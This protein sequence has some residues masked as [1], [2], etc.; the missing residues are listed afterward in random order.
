MT[1]PMYYELS[2]KNTRVPETFDFKYSANT[3]AIYDMFF[4]YC[5]GSPEEFAD[6]K[7]PQTIETFMTGKAPMVFYIDAIRETYINRRKLTTPEQLKGI[8]TDDDI[9]IIPVYLGHEKENVQNVPLGVAWTHAVNKNA[10]EEQKKYAKEFIDWL[11]F[12][13]SGRRFMREMDYV[14]PYTCISEK[15]IPDKPMKKYIYKQLNDKT[16]DKIYFTHALMPSGP[17]RDK[18]AGDLL[19][20][21]KGEL[22]WEQVSDNLVNSWSEGFKRNTANMKRIFTDVLNQ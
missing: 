16:K 19:A 12:S 9:G 13:E 17:Y 20:Y 3:K 8:L 14:L 7:L 15:D 11:V 4:K 18:Y 22:T 1:A 21:A 10:G 2:E 5:I 6:T